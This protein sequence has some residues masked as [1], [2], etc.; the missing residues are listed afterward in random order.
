MKILCL[1]PSF[2]CLGWALIDHT[3]TPGRD[4]LPSLVDW[5]TIKVPPSPEK[6]DLYRMQTMVK[7]LDQLLISKRPQLVIREEVI[8]SKSATANRLLNFLKG[9]IMGL[10]QARKIRLETV[11][12]ADAK[13]HT[14]GDRKADK[15]QIIN[16]VH[17]R[18]PQLK[19]K[20]MNKMDQEGVCDAIALYITFLEA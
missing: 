9:S 17:A 13:F 18:F 2:S 3:I 11:S 14:T 7:E 19:N 1:D 15:K 4:E 10:C 20:K 6:G 8:G 5:G 12:A 16:S